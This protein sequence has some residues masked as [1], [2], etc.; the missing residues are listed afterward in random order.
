MLGSLRFFIEMSVQ[1]NECSRHSDYLDKSKNTAN[2][3][4]Y[5]REDI[6][7]DQPF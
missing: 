1:M 5:I 3:F 7:G 2:V 4:K 6:W